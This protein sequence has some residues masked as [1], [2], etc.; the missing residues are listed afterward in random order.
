MTYFPKPRTLNWSFGKLKQHPIYFKN[1]L[2][3]EIE[4][5]SME[6]GPRMRLII[7]LFLELGG[8]LRI[9]GRGRQ[10]DMPKN[11]LDRLQIHAI[12]QPMSRYGM[13]DRMGRH[14][15]Y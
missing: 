1:F 7:D 5:H 6:L 11:H 15:P 13:T 4:K 2:L 3:S 12:F 9:N 10:R 8:N 14:I